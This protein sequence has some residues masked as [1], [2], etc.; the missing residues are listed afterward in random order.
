MEK[1]QPLG[2]SPTSFQYLGEKKKKRKGRGSRGNAEVREVCQDSVTGTSTYTSCHRTAVALPQALDLAAA[3]PLPGRLCSQKT[4]LFVR[5]R[6]HAEPVHIYAGKSFR[7]KITAIQYLQVINL[8]VNMSSLILT[9]LLDQVGAQLL[10]RQ[11][12]HLCSF[13]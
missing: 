8:S 6:M 12:F 13:P 10:W 3:S 9:L 2:S 5:W 1:S 4:V 11:K 7:T